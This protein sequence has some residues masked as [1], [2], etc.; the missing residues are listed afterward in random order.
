MSIDSNR[1]TSSGLENLPGLRLEIELPNLVHVPILGTESANEDQTFRLGVASPGESRACQRR[2][3]FPRLFRS[4]QTP[5]LVLQAKPP[6]I[7]ESVVGQPF[8]VDV[9]GRKTA[10]N[11]DLLFPKDDLRSVKIPPLRHRR[12]R[13]RLY[14]HWHPCVVLRVEKTNVVQWSMAQRISPKHPQTSSSVR[15]QTVSKSG[16]GSPQMVQIFGEELRV[17]EFGE[18]Q[19]IVL[20]QK[21]C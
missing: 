19:L 13:R 10:V 17:E 4:H 20:E 15:Y 21:K 1:S 3:L 8:R 11:E 14:S 9:F 16:Q 6:E 2:G 7:A 18:H 12:F 5:P